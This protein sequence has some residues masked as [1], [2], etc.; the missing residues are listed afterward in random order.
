[1]IIALA[2]TAAGPNFS[3][4][5]LAADWPQFRGPGGLGN[6]KESNLPLQ[7]SETDNIAWRVALPGFGSS[8]PITLGEKVYLTCYSGYG[9]GDESQAMQDLVLHVLCV[10]RADGH[11]DWDK[12]IQPRLPET[13]RVRDHGY[14]GPTPATDGEFLYVFLG[15]TGVFKFDLHGK[16]LWHADVGSKTH[17]WGCGASPVLYENLVIINASV[18]SGLLIAIDQQ[19][20]R[21]VCARKA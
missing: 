7:W 11:V 12:S 1:M 2:L 14:A 19:T 21:E 20:G 9:T 6:S 13:E 5:C 3:S 8:S 10:N 18:E 16:Q 17:G 4:R 15:K